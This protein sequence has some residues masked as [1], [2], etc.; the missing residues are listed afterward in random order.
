M[1]MIINAR[2]LYTRIIYGLYTD[3]DNNFFMIIIVLSL[4][5][6]IIYFL[7]TQ[8]FTLFFR[9]NR[10]LRTRKIKASIIISKKT[11]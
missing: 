1:I 3:V 6:L 9:V 2:R 4:L 7:H 10:I 11:F 8:T 5:L